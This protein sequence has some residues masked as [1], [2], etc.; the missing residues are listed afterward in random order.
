MLSLSG[1]SG[2]AKAKTVKLEAHASLTANE[3]V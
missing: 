1:Q 2:Y 3:F